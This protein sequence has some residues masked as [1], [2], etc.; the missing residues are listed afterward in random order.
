ML[1]ISYLSL[2]QVIWMFGHFVVIYILFA[3]YF[4]PLF[5]RNLQKKIKEEQEIDEK[6]TILSNKINEITEKCSLYK[7][8][9]AQYKEKKMLEVENFLLQEKTEMINKFESTNIKLNLVNNIEKKIIDTEENSEQSMLEY[10]KIIC[11]KISNKPVNIIDLK[12]IY[13]KIKI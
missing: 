5:K 1:D 3:Y 11:E 6:L 13:N 9:I 7:K 4:Y 8:N 10:A 12:N 2:L